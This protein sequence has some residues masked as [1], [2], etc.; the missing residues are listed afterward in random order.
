MR[1]GLLQ[2]SNSH[3]LQRRRHPRMTM[4]HSNAAQPPLLAGAPIHLP[5]RLES[6]LVRGQL[7]HLGLARP[8]VGSRRGNPQAVRHRH[9]GFQ[10]VCAPYDPHILDPNECCDPPHF[11]TPDLRS[12]STSSA[13]NPHSDNTSSVC[14]PSSGGGRLRLHGDAGM[15]S[16]RPGSWT[17]PSS[18]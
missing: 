11:T 8:A 10:S 17:S 9:R 4:L 14:S 6:F 2:L 7:S 13:P 1:I 3:L 5:P 16:G 18:A 12:A 15:I